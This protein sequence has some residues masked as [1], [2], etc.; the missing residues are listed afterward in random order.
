MQ[1]NKFLAAV[2]DIGLNFD[3]TKDLD[4]HCCSVGNDTFLYI[5]DIVV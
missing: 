3:M 1:L 4:K 5:Q 2:G